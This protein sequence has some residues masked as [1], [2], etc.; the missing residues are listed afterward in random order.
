MIYS[1]S[2]ERNEAYECMVM[3]YGEEKME[4][5]EEA[6]DN[7]LAIVCQHCGEELRQLQIKIRRSGNVW[8]KIMKK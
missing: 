8:S 4:A 7:C 6:R 3:C 2:E 1:E 5:R